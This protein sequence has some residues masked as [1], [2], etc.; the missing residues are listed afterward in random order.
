MT[1][2]NLLQLSVDDEIMFQYD[3]STKLTVLILQLPAI[4]LLIPSDDGMHPRDRDVAT[5]Y[6]TR[7]ASTHLDGF[8]IYAMDEHETFR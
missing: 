7:V 1:T 4:K 6:F 3:K 5:P 8:I 2:S